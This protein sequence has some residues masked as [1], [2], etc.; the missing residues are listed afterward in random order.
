M[1]S[2]L[3]LNRFYFDELSEDE[4]WSLTQSGLDWPLGQEGPG[5]QP[6]KKFSCYCTLNDDL[7][8]KRY[9]E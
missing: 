8:E 1:Y 5:T 6:L 9:D 3:F 7:K 2:Y 4:K